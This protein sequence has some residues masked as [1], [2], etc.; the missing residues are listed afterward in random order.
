MAIPWITLGIPAP[1]AGSALPFSAAR[2]R[3]IAGGELSSLSPVGA[4]LAMTDNFGK[5]V[6]LNKPEELGPESDINRFFIQI[7][8]EKCKN[9][10]KTV[11][12]KLG[13]A[14]RFPLPA[15]SEEA[16]T[17]ASLKMRFARLDKT[18]SA[19]MG[20]EECV[21]AK[22]QLSSLAPKVESACLRVFAAF[23]LSSLKSPGKQV[24]VLGKRNRFVI[25]KSNGVL[26]G[27]ATEDG[28]V[29]C[30]SAVDQYEFETREK[31]TISSDERNDVVIKNNYRISETK[32]E[33]LCTN[34]DIPAIEIKKTYTLMS[35]RILSKRVEFQ[36][37]KGEDCKVSGISRV[38]L[39]NN[40]RKGGL[41]SRRH[42]PVAYPK[43]KHLTLA[44]EINR[45]VPLRHCWTS[46]RGTG[47]VVFTNKQKTLG[48]AQYQ[49]KINDKFTYTPAAFKMSYLTPQGWTLSWF[50]GVLKDNNRTS[51]EMRYH[52]FAGDRMRFHREYRQTAGWKELWKEWMPLTW[53]SRIHWSDAI[54]W[55][56][57]PKKWGPRWDEHV[58]SR[59][60]IYERIGRPADLSVSLTRLTYRFG[61][62]PISDNSLVSCAPNLSEKST[63]PAT[64][65]APRFRKLAEP[66]SLFLVGIYIFPWD[67]SH[68]AGIHKTHPEWLLHN[69]QGKL[70]RNMVPQSG[71][72]ISSNYAA[73]PA[74]EGY[75]EW[76]V[77]HIMK[78]TE[79][80][81]TRMVYLDGSVSVPTIDWKS[82]RLSS[83]SDGLYFTKLLGEECRK[84]NIV[85]FANSSGWCMPPYL[86]TSFIESVNWSHWKDWRLHADQMA[87]CKLYA[88]PYHIPVMLYWRENNNLDYINTLVLLGLRP[89]QP[90]YSRERAEPY[91]ATSCEMYGYE[92]VDVDLRPCYWM[93]ETAIEAYSLQREK[94]PGVL[95]TFLNHKKEPSGVTL[96]FNA[97]KANLDI[98]KPLYIWYC[99]AKSFEELKAHPSPDLFIVKDARD[100]TRVTE[101]RVEITLKDVSP[102]IAKQVYVSNVPLFVWGIAGK[103]TQVKATWVLDTSIQQ[104]AENV[105]EISCS[106]SSSILYVIPETKRSITV[107]LD[108]KQVNSQILSIGATRV[109]VF[110][111]PVGT[112]T[113]RIQ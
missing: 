30:R 72:I 102:G 60:R 80:L 111:V 23:S 48:V 34:P 77:A 6:F 101:G 10:A 43:E 42:V 73:F 71:G 2:D 103:P 38:V 24:V 68:P 67:I 36:K 39:D 78:M 97:R 66:D 86:D 69:R 49:T 9:K 63:F 88:P 13:N 95:L 79:Y 51:C 8:S 40:F 87:L 53:A 29:L 61:D 16:L 31:K 89:Q 59:A 107:L 57:H 12:R 14:S 65:Y 33:F 17:L 113:I 81:K 21:E 15:D 93:E 45:D 70:V 22:V 75:T 50:A 27:I 83:Q 76:R 64:D 92:L 35:D 5:L 26:L 55:A 94:H 37:T 108:G 58:A 52:I 100:R 46:N 32:V 1:S 19:T 109:A 4:A 44:D 90:Y 18:V 54:A 47:L 105:F 98:R 112:H 84:R 110:D 96:S 20:L 25:L 91:V 7:A 99:D 104:E 82:M 56:H 41:Y 11:A 74:A 106:R 85:L 28:G 62:L 3:Y